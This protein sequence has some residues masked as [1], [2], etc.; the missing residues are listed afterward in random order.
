V[1]SENEARGLLTSISNECSAGRC[2]DCP[3]LFERE[4]TGSEVICCVHYCHHKESEFVCP[5]CGGVTVDLKAGAFQY[6]FGARVV[7]EHCREE[8]VVEDHPTASA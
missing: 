7:C 5:S 2:V 1:M 6:L 4:E 8:F 3:R